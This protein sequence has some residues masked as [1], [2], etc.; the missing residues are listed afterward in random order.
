MAGFDYLID[1][2]Y[3]GVPAGI[4]FCLTSCRY[5]PVGPSPF[6]TIRTYVYIQCSVHILLGPVSAER[7]A[8]PTNNTLLS[9]DNDGGNDVS[10]E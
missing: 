6:R 3:S 4:P 8:E 7:K 9:R 2:E 10:L 1:S 5:S